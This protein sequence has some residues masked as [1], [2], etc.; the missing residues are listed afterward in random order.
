MLL[1][2]RDEKRNSDVERN[3][4]LDLKSPVPHLIHCPVHRKY[5]NLSD[6]DWKFIRV[7]DPDPLEDYHQCPECSRMWTILLPHKDEVL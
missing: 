7:R 2:M 3:H 4:H 1:M 6:K 5:E